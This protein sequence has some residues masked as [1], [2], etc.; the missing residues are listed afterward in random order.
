MTPQIIFLW[1]IVVMAI[2]LFLS[3]KLRPDVI[4]MLVVPSLGING[5]LTSLVKGPSVRRPVH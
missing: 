5:I 3:V 2:I 1:A 4:A